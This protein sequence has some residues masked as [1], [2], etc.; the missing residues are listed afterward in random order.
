MKQRDFHSTLGI[1]VEA[2]ASLKC[3][4][5]CLEDALLGVR[6]P[7]LS[8]SHWLNHLLWSM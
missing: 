4:A 2:C 8:T 1:L 7:N 5:I 6:V 3:S